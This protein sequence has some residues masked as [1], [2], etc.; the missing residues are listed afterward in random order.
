MEAMF[1]WLS[2][3]SVCA[4]RRKRP[5]RSAS[6]ANAADSAL[7]ATSRESRVSRARYTSPMPPLPSGAMI[8]YGPSRAPEPRVSVIRGPGS[9]HLPYAL[10]RAGTT[11]R[12]TVSRFRI[13][14]VVGLGARAPREV[15]CHTVPP[16]ALPQLRLLAH[17]ECA[18]ERRDH[19][20]GLEALEE[21]TGAFAGQRVELLDRVGEPAG[22]SHDRRG[23]VA[24]AVHLVEAA[25]LVARRH[26]IEIRAAFDQV[27]ERLV[28]ARLVGETIGV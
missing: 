27:R 16:D 11:G 3:A 26:E 9:R 14:T 15:L 12:D 25:R 6:S 19:L 28:V 22:R 20:A 21:E 5:S 23:T 24:H 4:S 10:E 2:A 17:R 7:I 18:T 1:G 13:H 8:S